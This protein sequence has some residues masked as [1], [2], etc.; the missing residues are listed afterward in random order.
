MP[1]PVKAVCRNCGH[2]AMADQFKLHYKFK[3]M[4]CPNCFSGKTQKQKEEE[5]KKQEEE[6]KKPA[7]WDKEDEYIEKAYSQ[8]MQQQSSFKRTET[9]EVKYSCTGCKYSFRY[10]PI[11]QMPQGCPYCNKPIPKMKV[12]NSM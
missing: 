8:K 4:V 6:V 5:Q 12:F 7:A 1:T 10:D 2:E 11:K 3:M 9:G